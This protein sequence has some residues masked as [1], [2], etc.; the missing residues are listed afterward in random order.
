MHVARADAHL[1]EY[2]RVACF[3]QFERLFDRADNVGHIRARIN[4]PNLA[5]HRE[6]MR[7]FLDDA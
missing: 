2:G 6:R 7:T 1:Q 4:Q 5:F 3:R